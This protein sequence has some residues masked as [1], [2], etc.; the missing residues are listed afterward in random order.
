MGLIYAPD[1]IINSGGVIQV[2]DEFNGGYNEA[3]ARMSIDRVYDQIEKVFAIAERDGIPSYKAA[4]ILAEER[5]A[6]VRGTRS[7]F[8]QHTKSILNR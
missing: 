8:N 6:A 5:I 3:R 1:Y 4:D 2:A 7:I